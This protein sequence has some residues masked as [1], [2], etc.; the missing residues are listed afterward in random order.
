MGFQK[1]AKC[2][3]EVRGRCPICKRNVTTLE[4][5]IKDDKLDLY[6]HEDCEK[7]RQV[8]MSKSSLWDLDMSSAVLGGW[9]DI[10]SLLLQQ[11]SMSVPQYVADPA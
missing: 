4:S 8:C 1:H 5:R 3:G 9:P 11:S 6:L 2:F 7:A 10:I